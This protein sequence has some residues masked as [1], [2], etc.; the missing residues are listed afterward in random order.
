MVLTYLPT[1]L[2]EKVIAHTLPEGFES[3]AL[4]CKQIHATCTPFIQNHNTLHARFHDFNYYENTSEVIKTIRTAFDVITR[5]AIE[6]VVAR[7]I[8]HADFAMDSRFT[9]GRPRE[10]LADVHSGGTVLELLANSPHLRQ[11]GLDWQEFYATIRR[12]S[13]SRPLFPTCC[14]LS[15]DATA[16]C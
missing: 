12:G 15:Y 8:R 1:E 4:S 10:L 3:V 2:L 14:G 11:A 6:P 5:I 9:Q 13:G 16:Q 7:N